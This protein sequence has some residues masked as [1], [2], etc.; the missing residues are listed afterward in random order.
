M[1]DP[2]IKRNKSLQ[3]LIPNDHRKY[4]DDQ[5]EDLVEKHTFKP[6]TLA[7]SR[8]LAEQYNK[9]ILLEKTKSRDNLQQS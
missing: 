9:K 4:R 8:K 5:I 7:K 3:K 1:S 6:S 2:R